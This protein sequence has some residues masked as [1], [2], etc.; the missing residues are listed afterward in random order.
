MKIINYLSRWTAYVSAVVIILLM[1]LVV[2]DVCGRYFF[3]APITG[4]A[5]L[6]AFMMIVIVFP[7][8][9]WAAVTGK[10]VKVDI[11]MEHFPRRVQI[12]VDSLTLLGALGTYI[13]ITWQNVLESMV[14]HT[15][16]SQLRLAHAPFYWIMTVGLAIFCISI[17]AIEIG[18]ITK[19]VKR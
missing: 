14:Q 11:L 15:A 4:T 6:A 10:H 1:L 12:I 13:I 8:L 3:D 17:A 5:E 9:A 18:N 19:A 2:A 7:S 16:T